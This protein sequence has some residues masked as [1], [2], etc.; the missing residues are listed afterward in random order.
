MEGFFGVGIPEV[1]LILVLALI[2]LGPQDMVSTARKLGRWV[3]RAYHSPIWRQI[4]ST[5]AELRELPT[6]FVREAGLEDTI[7]D[8]KKT[9][10]DVKADLKNAAG[11][12]TSELT[13]AQKDVSGEIQ[14]AATQAASEVEQAAVVAKAGPAGLEPAL[15]QAEAQSEALPYHPADPPDEYSI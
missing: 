10:A 2:I 1:L 14:A 15:V 7:E 5:S 4:V 11:Q 8:L 9:Q 12:V 6:R 13:Q 3:Y